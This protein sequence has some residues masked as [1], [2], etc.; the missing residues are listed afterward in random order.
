MGIY[1]NLFIEVEEYLGDA[2]NEGMTNE[3]AIKS[4]ANEM[5]ERKDIVFSMDEME[6]LGKWPL[7]A[8]LSINQNQS[9]TESLDLVASGPLSE[10]DGD[11]ALIAI[12]EIDDSELKHLGQSLKEFLKDRKLIITKDLREA[13]KSSN[14]VVVTALGKTRNQELIDTRKM[15]LLQKKPILGLVVINKL[16]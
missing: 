15:L 3:Q 13:T 6:S 8:E 11:I 14:L 9:W 16:I 7:L 4:V 10:S 1:K 12:G 2:L 5:F